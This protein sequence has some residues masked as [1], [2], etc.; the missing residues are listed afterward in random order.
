MVTAD[1]QST[2][3]PRSSVWWKFHG[4]CFP[5]ATEADSRRRCERPR[6]DGS[7]EGST[8]RNRAVNSPSIMEMSPC[9]WPVSRL[10]CCGCQAEIP[11]KWALSDKQRAELARDGLSQK[12]IIINNQELLKVRQAAD[13]GTL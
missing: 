8:L 9:I 7:G 5:A 11:V 1:Y 12:Q 6:P 3:W 10:T 4:F 13:A 2:P